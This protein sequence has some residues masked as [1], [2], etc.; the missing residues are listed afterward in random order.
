MTQKNQSASSHLHTTP[1][2]DENVLVTLDD[3][4][5]LGVDLGDLGDLS[6]CSFAYQKTVSNELELV[7]S[8]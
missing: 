1:S 4:G 5:D 8:L 2:L 7:A 6:I 3:L